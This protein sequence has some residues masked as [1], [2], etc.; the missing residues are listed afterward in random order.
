[1][2]PPCSPSPGSLSPA[3][4][5]RP[6]RSLS[7]STH[8]AIAPADLDEFLRGQPPAAIL[9]GVEPEDLEQP[10]LDYARMHDYRAVPL[11]TAITL[12]VPPAGR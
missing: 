8:R 3:P 10:L 1:M 9:L 11:N 5:R 12:W 2:R 4:W 7:T 6:L